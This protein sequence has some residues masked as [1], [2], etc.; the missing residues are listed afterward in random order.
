MGF[1]M[2]FVPEK[3]A[4]Q[5]TRLWEAYVKLQRGGQPIVPPRDVT[6]DTCP[7]IGE[8]CTKQGCKSCRIYAA[9]KKRISERVKETSG[10]EIRRQKRLEERLKIRSEIYRRTTQG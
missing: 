4:E 1:K 10:E 2:P 5:D 8:Y 7:I 6:A 3:E 9:E